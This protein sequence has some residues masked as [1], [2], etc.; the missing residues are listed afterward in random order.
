MSSYYFSSVKIETPPLDRLYTQKQTTRRIG[1]R[2]DKKNF[3]VRTDIRNK[4]GTDKNIPRSKAMEN[5]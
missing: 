5:G 1:S 3:Q 2:K 4:A